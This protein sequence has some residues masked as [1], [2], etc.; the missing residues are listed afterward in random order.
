MSFYPGQGGGT[1]GPSVGRAHGT[2]AILIVP[3]PL[4]AYLTLAS[5]MKMGRRG[6]LEESGLGEVRMVRA[7]PR[8]FGGSVPVLPEALC[9]TTMQCGFAVARGLSTWIEAGS[10]PARTPWAD[11]AYSGQKRRYRS[12][13]EVG[14]Q[15]STDRLPRTRVFASFGKACGRIS[16]IARRQCWSDGAKKDLGPN[17]IWRGSEIDVHALWCRRLGM[18]LCGRSDAE[19]LGRPTDAA[20]QKDSLRLSLGQGAPVS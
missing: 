1:G 7:T 13:L 17:A 18:L 10:V 3:R 2:I 11:R 20:R 16:R 5:E 19:N 12:D 15:P 9:G 6:A 14:T 4:S 8:S